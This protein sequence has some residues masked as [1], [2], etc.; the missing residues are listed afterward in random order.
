MPEKPSWSRQLGLPAISGSIAV[1]FSH[2]LELT[3]ARLQLDNELA[4]RGTPR[5]YSGWTDC[6]VKNWRKAGI[7]GLQR[8]LTLGVTREFFFNG[9]RIG[10]VEPMVDLVQSASG[11]SG[12]APLPREKLAGGLLAGALGG[13][14]INPL[15][16][17]KT[18]AQIAGGETGFQHASAQHGAIGS[19]VALIR[20]EGFRG[21]FRGIGV[22]TLRGFLGP[23]SQITSY[24]MLKEQAARHGGKWFEPDSVRT[25]IACSLASAA[26]SIACVNP[27]DVIRTRVY[28]QPFG[29]DGVGLRY[30]SALDATVKLL[31]TEGPLA[32]YKGAGVHY[33]RLGPHMVLVFV[34]LEKLKKYT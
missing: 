1:C 3:K 17:C 13:L 33:A 21:L 16:V 5:A 11:N 25:H 10:G 12:K 32:F 29:P 23:G 34:I 14:L 31:S 7:R 27:V 9:I 19:L 20:E 8:G 22:N 15:D 18:R 4:Q 24:S 30:S 2:P 26:V 28:N 6:V